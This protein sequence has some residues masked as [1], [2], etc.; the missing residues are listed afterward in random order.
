MQ[1]VLRKILEIPLY[2]VHTLS[3][4]IISCVFVVEEFSFFVEFHKEHSRASL[5]EDE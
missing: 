5:R 4:K 3:R 2:E 1:V